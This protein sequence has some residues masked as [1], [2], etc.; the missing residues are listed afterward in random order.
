MLNFVLLLICAGFLNDNKAS[1][2]SFDSP[3]SNKI[4]KILSSFHRETLLSIAIATE[5]Y[6]SK[7]ENFKSNYE[8][9]IDHLTSLSDD[10]LIKGIVEETEDHPEIASIHKLRVLANGDLKEKAKINRERMLRSLLKN[11]PLEPI[12]ECAIKMEDFL[13]KEKNEKTNLKIDSNN[14]EEIIENILKTVYSNPKL[15]SGYESI[16]HI[17]DFSM[18]NII[19]MEETKIKD[20]MPLLSKEV[21]KAYC[22]VFE[23]YDMDHNP[24]RKSVMEKYLNKLKKRQL[25]G[26][27][28]IFMEKYPE[29]NTIKRIEE[30]RKEYN[31]PMKIN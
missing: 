1:S 18:P 19:Y 25:I 8:G 22:L 27:L 30:K 14:R 29:L 15:A 26:F 12:R 28:N 20:I 31:I 16:C 21:L 17:F 3:R 9:K 7:V 13:E 11:Y 6:H 23:R 24:K 10:Q 4:A 5:E 2:L